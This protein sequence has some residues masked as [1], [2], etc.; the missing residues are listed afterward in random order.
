[1]TKAHIL[2]EI[3]R[4]AE[5]K[6]GTALGA[7]RFEQETGIKPWDWQK[8]W[9]RFGDA[10]REAG[11]TQS[12]FVTAY[13]AAELLGKYAQLA[14]D[15]GRLP[16][17]GDLRVKAH[18]EPG[19]PSDKAFSRWGGKPEL[20][21]RL[22]TYCKEH[23]QFEDVLQLCSEYSPRS[24]SDADGELSKRKVIGFVYLVK[25]GRFYKIGKTNAA[26]RREYELAIQLPEKAVQ[27][28]IIETDDPTGIEAYWHR[29]FHDKRKNGEWFDLT[30]ADIVAFKKWRK[31]A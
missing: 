26:G 5:A 21:K 6:G 29:R 9:P 27:V 18:A 22:A 12:E 31:I 16:V 15:L 3:K 17:K 25:S 13:D 10:V 14:R 30:A 19:F 1:M 8:F 23:E 28:H 2:Q 4:T 20:I 11:C 24:Q 7:S